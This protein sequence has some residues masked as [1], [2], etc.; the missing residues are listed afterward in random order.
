MFD[1]VRYLLL[2][3]RNPDDPMRMQEVR[4]F[5]RALSTTTD[6]IDVADLLHG[7][8]APQQ[9]AAADVLLLGGSGHY[10]A[11]GAGDWLN[12]TFD[13][14]RDLY[15]EQRPTFASCWGFQAMARVLGGRVVKDLSRAEVG[16]HRLFLTPEGHEDPVF[17][18]LGTTFSG[19][20]GHEDCVSEL[21]A[22]AVLLASS[23]KVV[24]Q[25][26]RLSGAPIYCTQFH[27]E[28]NCD[29]LLQR[30]KQYPE[31]VERIAGVPAVH[32]REMIS[33]SR[34]TEALLLRFVRL[35]LE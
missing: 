3:V 10:S 1:R 13:L 20:M 14:L 6:R 8:P 18:P 5:A 35:V 32:F 23:D 25:A 31:Y 16:T 9:L 7:G 15:A 19:Q 2:Q 28:L 17:G 33:D 12:R 26:Y 22:D 24:N 11:T 34:A 29:D 30:V 21:P 27:P 4:C